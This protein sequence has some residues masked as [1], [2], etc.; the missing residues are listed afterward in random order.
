MILKYLPP[1]ANRTLMVKILSTRIGTDL[2]LAVGM[3]LFRGLLAA[4]AANA[5]KSMPLCITS[6][7]TT[8]ICAAI[9]RYMQESC[10][11][12]YL[13]SVIITDLAIESILAAA[14][15]KRNGIGQS[16][17]IGTGD[18]V[19]VVITIF[20]MKRIFVVIG[21]IIHIPL[22]MQALLCILTIGCNSKHN[23]IVPCKFL[24]FKVIVT[25]G[26]SVIGRFSVAILRLRGDH[27][28]ARRIKAADGAD[29]LGI[30]GMSPLIRDMI[31]LVA[32]TAVMPMVGLVI[33]PARFRGSGVPLSSAAVN[34]RH[35]AC[36]IVCVN[37]YRISAVTSF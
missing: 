8:V 9:M 32:K 23:G 5:H 11:A 19:L 25:I 17:S 6:A 12:V 3:G 21:S 18:I 35:V 2:I 7:F 10:L 4:S 29:S 34:A 26:P 13:V 31:G 33:S 28:F 1:T 22:I 20:V 37:A 30:K 14:T 24:Q 16:R 27:D 15:I 36:E